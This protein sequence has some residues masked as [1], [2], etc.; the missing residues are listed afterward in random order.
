[1]TKN[2]DS[3]NKSTLMEISMR[4]SGWTIKDMEMELYGLWIREGNLSDS[5]LGNGKIIRDGDKALCSLTME[6]DMT[7]SGSTTACQAMED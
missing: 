4:A 2:P 5:I 7:V 3:G 1:M 6:I